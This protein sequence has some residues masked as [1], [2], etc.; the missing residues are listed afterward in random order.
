MRDAEFSRFVELNATRLLRFA[1]LLTGNPSTAEDLLQSVL[2]KTYRRWSRVGQADNPD[3]YVR[4]A[5]VNARRR[6]WRGR[7]P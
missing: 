2:E 5:L 4:Q 6:H 1:T 3:A 7:A